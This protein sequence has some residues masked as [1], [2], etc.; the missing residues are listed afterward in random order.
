MKLFK[1][2]IGLLLIVFAVPMAMAQTVKIGVVDLNRALNESEEG[3]RSKNILEA[4]GRQKQQ[5]FQL[6][7]EDL[8]KQFQALQDN[9]LITAEAK[10]QK[11]AEL[12][13]EEQALVQRGRQFEQ[14]IRQKER[15]LTAEIFKE[16]RAVIRTVAQ[17][18][19]L[20]FVLERNFSEAILYMNHDVIDTTE[21]VI[22][23]YNSLKSQ[24]GN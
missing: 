5:E 7:Q 18:E 20:D 2:T 3:I 1:L 19:K 17:R 14:E 21:K 15:Q 6:A 8:R 9:L 4:E 11:E 10:Q 12:R 24:K 22:D 23:H 16:L 13:K